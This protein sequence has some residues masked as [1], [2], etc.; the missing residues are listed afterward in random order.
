MFAYRMWP[1]P[2]LPPEP[3]EWGADRADAGDDDEEEEGCRLCARA[4][5]DRDEALLPFGLVSN[6]C[7]PSG[8]VRR[9]FISS[10]LRVSPREAKTA[11]GSDRPSPL[12]SSEF[13]CTVGKLEW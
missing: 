3:P 1:P 4:V 6:T 13:S 10:R 12:L 7:W 2:A 8:V 11:S 9:T 5:G